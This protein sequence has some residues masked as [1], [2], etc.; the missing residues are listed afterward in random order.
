MTCQDSCFNVIYPQNTGN[1]TGKRIKFITGLIRLFA[2]VLFA[3]AFSCKTCDCPAYSL[4]PDISEEPAIAH[5]C[6]K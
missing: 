6:R 1:P 3:A 2:I 5:V 4:N